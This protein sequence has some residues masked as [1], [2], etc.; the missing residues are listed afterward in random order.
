MVKRLRKFQETVSAIERIIDTE[1]YLPRYRAAWCLL[2]H[3]LN[4]AFD[5]DVRVLHQAAFGHIAIEADQH[6][7][8]IAA[9]ILG[10]ASA[11]GA[12]KIGG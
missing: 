3:V 7:E 5:F 8:A 12:T 9:K 10:D 2:H 11:W 4:R 1:T 6:V